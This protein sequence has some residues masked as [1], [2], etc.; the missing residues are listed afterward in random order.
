MPTAGIVHG[1]SLKIVC[2]VKIEPSVKRLAEKNPM[3]A[4]LKP[5]NFFKSFL[6]KKEKRKDS[7]AS[8]AVKYKI[9]P[10]NSG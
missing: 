9:P 1:S 7:A 3:L 5:K 8:T 6:N 10:A 4:S 2:H